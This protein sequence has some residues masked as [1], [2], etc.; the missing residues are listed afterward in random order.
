M[1][2]RILIVAPVALFALA[3]CAQQLAPDYSAFSKKLNGDEQIL[4]ALNRLTFGPRVGD[5]DAVKKMG[6]D[7]WMD[8]QLHPERIPGNPALDAETKSFV[9]PSPATFLTPLQTAFAC[10]ERV[11]N[12][13]L[14]R[15]S[16]RFLPRRLSRSSKPCR[17]CAPGWDR[18]SRP[19]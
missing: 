5:V 4:Q 17:E 7:Q 9:E 10:F 8:L 1:I 18:S 14:L 12:S 16:N 13:K 15:S 6:L 11:Q 2:R 3:L 19:N